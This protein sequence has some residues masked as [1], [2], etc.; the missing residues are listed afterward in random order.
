[1]GIQVVDVGGGQL[2]HRK[3]SEVWDEVT[4]NDRAS[5]AGR[6]RCPRRRGC[7]EPPLQQIGHRPSSQPGIA[8]LGY[9]IGQL[10]L[11]VAASAVDGLVSQR[12]RL[13]PGSRPR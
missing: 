2:G 9:E 12:W 5:L 6:W 11:G 1:M 8:S 7:G 13:L 10:A 4:V 3:V